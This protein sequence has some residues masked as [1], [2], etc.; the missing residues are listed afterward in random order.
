VSLFKNTLLA[1]FF[2]TFTLLAVVVGSGIMGQNLAEGNDA[3]ALLANS[4]A[5]G[6]GL[7]VLITVLGPISGAHFNPAVTV[8]MAVGGRFPLR[9]VIP[10]IVM[11]CLGGVLGVV[12]AN[13]MFDLPAINMST[14]M[15]D[16]GNLWF[17]EAIATAGLLATII[18]AVRHRPEA[19]ATSVAMYIT[20][21][22]WFTSS[23][24]FANPAVTLARSFSDTFAGIAPCCVLAF[25][26][27]QLLVA[28]FIGLVL[29]QHDRAGLRETLAEG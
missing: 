27:V 11:Q 16:T 2:G 4:L 1:E 21:A 23:T 14:T 29:R 24:S 20:A 18:L 28:V 17:S 15:R 12:A 7:Y 9:E 19:V 13:L 8:C 6:A 3:I 25:A 26:A 10:Y 22:Y 5:T